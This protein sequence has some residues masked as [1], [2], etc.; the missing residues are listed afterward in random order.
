MMIVIIYRHG[1]DGLAYVT[2]QLPERR[3]AINGGVETCLEGLEIYLI[4]SSY[5]PELTT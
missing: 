2:P 3:S 5:N 1:K 4:H